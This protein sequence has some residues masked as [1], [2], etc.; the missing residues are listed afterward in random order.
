[1]KTV[2]I[3][4]KII[5]ALIVL[6]PLLAFSLWVFVALLAFILLLAIVVKLSGG[7]VNLNINSNDKPLSPKN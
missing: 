4:A 6:V 7:R 1:M 5:I 2:K 3:I